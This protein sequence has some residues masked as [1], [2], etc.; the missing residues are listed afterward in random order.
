MLPKEWLPNS[1]PGFFN[2]R[3]CRR[4]DKYKAVG[5]GPAGPFMAGPTFRPIMRNCALS[6]S[7][8]IPGIYVSAVQVF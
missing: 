2:K 1:D 4:R 7:Q 3:I 5:S 6:L 8:T